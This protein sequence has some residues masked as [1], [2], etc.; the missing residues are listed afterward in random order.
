MSD[1]ADLRRSHRG[2]SWLDDL[3]RT[4]LHAAEQI[5]DG[6]PTERL[7]RIHVGYGL[8]ARETAEISAAVQNAVARIAHYLNDPKAESVRVLKKHIEDAPVYVRASYSQ[9]IEFG[10]G[11]PDNIVAGESPLF[12]GATAYSPGAVAARELLAVLPDAPADDEALDAMLSRSS[13][14]MNAVAGLSKAVKNVGGNLDLEL[15]GGG[16][17]SIASVLTNQQA[18]VLHSSLRERRETTRTI[19]TEGVLDG[20]RTRRRVFY[21]ESAEQ[22]DISGSFDA[23]L[24]ETVLRFLGQLVQVTVEETRSVSKS[25]QKGRPT[26]RL[27][28]L[29][30]PLTLLD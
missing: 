19:T 12:E 28:R 4:S 15:E 22:S 18:R 30:A 2:T 7:L 25:G 14:V 11:D 29:E 20:V 5:Y 24:H 23:G 10:F 9:V 27:I 16:V 8:N 13:A 1:F 17:E 21:L 6:V 3:V 26:Y